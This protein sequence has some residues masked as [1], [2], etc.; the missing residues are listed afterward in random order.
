MTQAPGRLLGFRHVCPTPRHT[1]I[2][3]VGSYANR[4]GPHALHDLSLS[5]EKV[6]RGDAYED[7]TTQIS[8]IGSY[9]H[10]CHSSPVLCCFR[11]GKQ[12][13]YVDYKECVQASGTHG[14]CVANQQK[15]KAP[16]GTGPY[17]L[18]TPYDTKWIYDDDLGMP[19]GCIDRKFSTY[20]N[21]ACVENPNR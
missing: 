5:P 19:H 2:S 6:N 17:C 4:R 9:Y 3:P 10:R 21:A 14:E 7:H 13:D 1:V 8:F 16:S 20:K 12:C 15:D 11:M 18:V